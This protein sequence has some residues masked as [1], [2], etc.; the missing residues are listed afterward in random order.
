MAG[1]GGD[2]GLVQAQHRGAFLPRLSARLQIS[3]GR[4]RPGLEHDGSNA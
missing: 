3:Y 4:D 1:F 2:R